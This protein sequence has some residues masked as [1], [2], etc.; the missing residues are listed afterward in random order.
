MPHA[1]IFDLD[2]CILDTHSLT[3]PFFKPVLDMLHSAALPNEQK[4]Q[5]EAQLWTTSLDDTI[6]LFSIPDDIA[7]AMRA[8]YL[9]VQ[10]PDGIYT[11]GDEESI[12]ALT[13]KKFLV[14]SG[15]RKFQQTKIDKLGIADL[16]DGIIIDA[17]DMP[18]QRK[19]KK[20]IFQEIMQ[21][22]GWL[23]SEI[24]VVGDNPLSELAAGKALG[25]ITV[26]T[27]R[28]TV[29]KWPE[30]DYHIMSLTELQNI[31]SWWTI[32]ANNHLRY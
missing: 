9:D 29:V 13:V 23:P 6:K 27:L 1:I 25:M 11:Y 32:W 31:I 17:S 15:Y 19:G 16:F 28:P 24:M 3:G 18:E 4:Q 22:N 30:A 12:R 21:T 20:V 14:T 5:I 7:T 10:V 2:M 8:A 26:Q